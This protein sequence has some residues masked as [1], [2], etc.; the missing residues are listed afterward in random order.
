MIPELPMFKRLL[1]TPLRFGAIRPVD[2]LLRNAQALQKAVQDLGLFADRRCA[3]HR[4]IE[5]LER[6]GQLSP[7]LIYLKVKTGGG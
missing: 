4:R 3:Q 2:Q 6:R 5:F 7:D 1:Q